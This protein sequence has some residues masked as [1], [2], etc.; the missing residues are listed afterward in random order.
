MEPSREAIEANEPLQTQLVQSQVECERLKLAVKELRA[1]NVKPDV[2]LGMLEDLKQQKD[3]A[4]AERDRLV[5]ALS[6][7]FPAS[8]ERHPEED[9]TWDNDWRWIVFIELPTGQAT[10]HIHDSELDWFAHLPRLTGEKWDGHSTEQKYV[11][12]SDIKPLG[13]NDD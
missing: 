1:I 12:L 13:S 8:L 11:R 5:A 3:V 2:T 7:V 10:W 9:R 4:Y 6:K